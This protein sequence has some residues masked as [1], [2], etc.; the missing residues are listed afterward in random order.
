MRLSSRSQ[1]RKIPGEKSI[2][3]KPNSLRYVSQ[4]SSYC[5]KEAQIF[6]FVAAVFQLIYAVSVQH[7]TCVTTCCI[8]VSANDRRLR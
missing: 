7:L 6:P 5:S 3:H 2:E 1:S 8:F 4:R